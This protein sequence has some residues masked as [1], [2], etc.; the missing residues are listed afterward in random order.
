MK[1]ILL[2]WLASVAVAVA[3]W[4][5]GSVQN[6][7]VQTLTATSVNVSSNILVN[8]TNVLDLAAQTVNQGFTNF[9]YSGATGNLLW[10]NG[11]NWSAT[12]NLFWNETDK[13]LHFGS[14][15]NYP[16]ISGLGTTNIMFGASTN[17]AIFDW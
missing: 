5:S 9:F 2:I 3:G 13:R 14:A 4:N 12:T 11:T 6:P 16:W 1:N 15:T 7:N 8:G 17:T 10:H